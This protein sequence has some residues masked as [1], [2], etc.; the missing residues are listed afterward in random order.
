MRC[1]LKQSPWFSC[2]SPR[3]NA[4]FRLFCF[5][6]AGAGASVFRQWAATADPNIEV[7][8]VQLPGRESR[9]REPLLTDVSSVVD[10]LIHDVVDLLD[11]P[12]SIFGH[13]LGALIG[14]EF[15]RR[16][17]KLSLPLPQRLFVSARQAPQVLLNGKKIHLLPEPHLKEELRLYAGTPEV[18]LQDNNMMRILLPIIRADLAMN[19]TY[20]YT[21]ASPV[22][23]P[24]SAFAGL[25]DSKISISSIEA[26]AAQTSQNFEVCYFDGDHF[27]IKQDYPSIL[28]FI[29]QDF[30]Q[31]DLAQQNL[32]K[33]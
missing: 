14:F 10:A 4:N 9:L 20:D 3:V 6:Y 32:I 12:F 30:D 13:S 29:N 18:V 25:K 2:Y 22:S 16:L 7:Q 11:K 15:T 31:K 27:F 24:I 8:G 26:W 33:I 19:E 23:C 5:P 28:N 1:T 17:Q 21:P